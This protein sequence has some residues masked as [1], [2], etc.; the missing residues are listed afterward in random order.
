MLRILIGLP[1][2]LVL[3]LFALSNP[4]PVQLGIWPTDLT[5]TVPMSVAIL[6]GMAMAFVIGALLLWFS[7]V[8]ARLRAR[9]AEHLTRLLNAQVAQLKAENERL[10]EAARPG[11]APQQMSTALTL[12]H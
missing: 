11:P 7:A 5:I 1:L 4:Q 8:A 10:H 3:V 9:R 12:N 2:L 6:F